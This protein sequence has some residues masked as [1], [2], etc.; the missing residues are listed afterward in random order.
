MNSE[1]GARLSM[2]NLRQPEGADSK[3]IH[4]R[5][6]VSFRHSRRLYT[7]LFFAPKYVF[8]KIK[9]FSLCKK[10]QLSVKLELV[11]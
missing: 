6:N 1:D 7:C 11:P 2:N 5:E 8:V 3:I 9:S 4:E 10:Y